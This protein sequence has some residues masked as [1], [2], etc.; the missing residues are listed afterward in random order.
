MIPLIETTH[1]SKNGINTDNHI[2]FRL[3]IALDIAKR[4]RG[5]GFPGRTQ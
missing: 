2:L 4:G 1:F 3:K 5:A